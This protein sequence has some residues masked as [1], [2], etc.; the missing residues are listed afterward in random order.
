ML[1]RHTSYI[2][3]T[4]QEICKETQQFYYA[5]GL[6]AYGIALYKSQGLGWDFPVTKQVTYGGD[7]GMLVFTKEGSLIT[8]KADY[9]GKVFMCIVKAH[10]DGTITVHEWHK[11]SYQQTLNRS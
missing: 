1:S 3:A 4:I 8:V 5:E 7:S 2:N 11:E 6:L 10:K 9:K